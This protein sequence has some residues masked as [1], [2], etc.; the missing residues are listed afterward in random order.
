[1]QDRPAAGDLLAAVRQFLQGELAPT[2][3]D[4]RLRFRALI[5]ANVLG[6]VERELAGEEERLRA[7]WDRL[8]ALLGGAWQMGEG[9][10]PATLDELRAGIVARKRELCG[11]IQAGEADDDPSR[12]EVLAYARWAV[13]EKLRVSNPRYL[14]RFTGESSG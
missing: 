14:A 9:T 2:L 1:M 8:G 11:R 5:A 10:A 3:G 4:P 7:E 12:R 13:E 6:I